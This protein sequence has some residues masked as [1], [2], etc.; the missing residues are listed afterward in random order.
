MLEGSLSSGT[1]NQTF[2]G[3]KGNYHVVSLPQNTRS[4]HVMMAE[5]CYR[6]TVIGVNGTSFQVREVNATSVTVNDTS[7]MSVG[8]YGRFEPQSSDFWIDPNVFFWD[9]AAP[10]KV[11]VFCNGFNN[12]SPYKFKAISFT[13][14][15]FQFRGYFFDQKTWVYLS[16]SKFNFDLPP[17]SRIQLKFFSPYTIS[18]F[19]NVTLESP[20]TFQAWGTE[21]YTVGPQIYNATNT[22][23]ISFGNYSI[24]FSNP[25]QSYKAASLFLN[26]IFEGSEAPP[27]DSDYLKIVIP[28]F[29]TGIV[30]ACLVGV[31][32]I[33]LIIV[34][35]FCRKKK[36][37]EQSPETPAPIVEPDS[38]SNTIHE[39]GRDEQIRV[40]NL[41]SPDKY[42]F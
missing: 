11:L 12:D 7:G 19:G 36:Q 1:S 16:G 39:L 13:N 18:M 31:A 6:F 15:P 20:A 37:A 24:N 28:L 4:V 2:S 27:S 14:D 35:C 5:G 10:K 8:L 21:N 41:K 26:A 3:S 40:N 9:A 32:I 23:S 42:N 22:A 33:V 34:C 38:A 17:N 29:I 25:S 30:L